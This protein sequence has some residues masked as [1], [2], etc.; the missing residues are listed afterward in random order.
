M[1]IYF[2]EKTNF[3]FKSGFKEMCTKG[4]DAKTIIEGTC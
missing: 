2:W 1:R 3:L 4:L